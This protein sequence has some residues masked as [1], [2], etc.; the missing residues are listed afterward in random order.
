MAAI[1]RDNFTAACQPW[2]VLAIGIVCLVLWARLDRTVNRSL[3]S[4][5]RTTISRDGEL[6]PP[7]VPQDN[8]QPPAVPA[9]DSARDR[10]TDEHAATEKARTDRDKVKL[11]QERQDKLLEQLKADSDAHAERLKRQADEAERELGRGKEAIQQTA[12]NA[13]DM[14]RSA[15]DEAAK[16]ELE[17]RELLNAGARRGVASAFGRGRAIEVQTRHDTRRFRDPAMPA[18]VANQAA[19]TAAG[20]STS[21]I[22]GGGLV[23][24]GSTVYGDAARGNALMIEAQG[25]AALR[26]S[27]AR[28]N[29][30]TALAM[31]IENRLRW[32]ETFF[33]MRRVN[34]VARAL[35]AGPMVTMEQAVR[36]AAAARPRR[37]S[38]IEL[39]PVTG[40]IA[41]P[42]LLSDTGYRDE[43]MAVQ[44][45]FHEKA[46]AMGSASYESSER[47]EAIFQQLT[48][49]L[50]ENVQRY[51][52]GKYGTARSFLD[53]LRQEYDMPQN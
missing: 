46:E 44:K 50:K 21:S 9:T 15:K 6:L 24:P 10:V 36:F 33:E 8:R 18:F 48:S 20:A 51:P 29:T 16:A 2:A 1:N 13:A 41:W 28:I 30:Q 5:A 27:Q 52:P 4:S 11:G 22:G 47:L 14:L 34:R 31:G 32:T 45:C 43:V 37:L 17:R 39:D 7:S 3:A 23:M 25:N 49:K 35:E 38:M 19:V 40:D 26:T 12:E 53:R 42:A